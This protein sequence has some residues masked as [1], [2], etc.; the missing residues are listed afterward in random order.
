LDVPSPSSTPPACSTPPRSV[1]PPAS[2]VRRRQSH[3]PSS[4]P[5]KSASKLKSVLP[6]V[7]ESMPR[8]AV[9]MES[10]TSSSA[11][12]GDTPIPDTSWGSFSYGESPYEPFGGS[13]E[14]TP[15]HSRHP[16]LY[17]QPSIPVFDPDPPR[18][19][20]PQPDYAT[21]VSLPT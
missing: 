12:N 10:I 11:L 19:Q 14:T 20:T 4:A 18:S 2:T 5:R 8:H 16:S 9:G 6:A 21:H 13:R 3:P 1:S 7:E 15:Q 17:S